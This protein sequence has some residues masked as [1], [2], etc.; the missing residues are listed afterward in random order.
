MKQRPTVSAIRIGKL[1]YQSFS[2]VGQYGVVQAALAQFL[3][4]SVLSAYLNSLI[5]PSAAG[6]AKSAGRGAVLRE[7]VE[8]DRK[9]VV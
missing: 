4:P 8:G 3:T 9:S 2:D 5:S 1:E 7:T 6:S